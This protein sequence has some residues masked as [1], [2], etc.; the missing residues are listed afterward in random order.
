MKN[1]SNKFR[2]NKN[3]EYKKNSDF[4]FYSKNKNRSEKNDR[5]LD[6]STKNR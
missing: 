6:N 1:S 3:K 2:G 5:F 4:G